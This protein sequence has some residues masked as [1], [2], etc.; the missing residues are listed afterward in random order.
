MQLGVTPDLE[1]AADQFSKSKNRAKLTEG[2]SNIGF[3]SLHAYEEVNVFL[4]PFHYIYRASRSIQL[5][6]SSFLTCSF[7]RTAVSVIHGLSSSPANPLAAEN[8]GIPIQQS[9]T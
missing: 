8:G 9:L 5:F 4:I 7:S 1:D 6:I 3:E 2:L